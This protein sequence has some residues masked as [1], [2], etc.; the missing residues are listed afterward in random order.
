[1]HDGE[2]VQSRGLTRRGM[3]A[4]GVGAFVVATIPLA[5]RHRRA[6][7]RRSIPVM[8]TLAEAVVVADDPARGQAAIDAAFDE[9]Q[10]VEALMSRFIDASDVGRANRGAAR[11]AVP[12]TAETAGVLRASLGWAEATDGAFDPGLGRAIRLW[13]VTHRRT[14]P[15]ETSVRPLAG[16]R[17]YRGLDVGP[18]RGGAAV[19]FA[20]RDVE[21]DLG[22]IAKGHGVD[23]AVDA[24]RRQGIERAILSVGGDLYALG[25]AGD[26]V[27]WRVGIQSPWAP[28]R[29]IEEIAVRDGAVATSGDYLRFF[30]YG[31]RRY[32]HLLDPST[33]APR[34]TPVHSVTVAADTCLAADAAATAVYGMS[35]EQARA[36]LRARPGSAR[37]VR[38]LA[39][40]RPTP[41]RV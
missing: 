26:G 38:A 4:L 41:A 8:G 32:H 27:P 5:A 28:D 3:L 18:W 13:D 10:R 24:L 33:A 11:E 2:P 35:A 25:D 9:L 30:A 34:V 36:V 37:L 29:V 7:V 20:T 1:M 22:G 16:R 14:P 19:R 23:R 31:G 15:P 17:L 12:V 39:G 6:L 40:D 21:V